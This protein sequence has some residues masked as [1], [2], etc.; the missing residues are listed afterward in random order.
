M[1]LLLKLEIKTIKKFIKTKLYNDD[2]N[3]TGLYSL[4][5]NELIV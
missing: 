4:Q 1:H 3:E 2:K 5:N